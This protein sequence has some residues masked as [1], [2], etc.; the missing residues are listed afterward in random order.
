MSRMFDLRDVF[1]LIN[2]GFNDAAFVQQEFVEKRGLA[3]IAFLSHKDLLL[4]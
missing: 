4:V 3:Q 1:Q 2:D